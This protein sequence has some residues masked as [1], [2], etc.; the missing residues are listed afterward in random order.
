[1]HKHIENNKEK[2]RSDDAFDG[3]AYISDPKEC[4]EETGGTESTLSKA[5][6][7]SRTPYMSS[8]IV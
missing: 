4:N 7:G 5:S 3:S 8:I 2:Y 1:M 6:S